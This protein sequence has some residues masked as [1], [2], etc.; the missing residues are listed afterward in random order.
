MVVSVLDLVARR[1][2]CR[3]DPSD[4]AGAVQRGER[5]VDGLQ[6]GAANARPDGL[7]ELGDAAVRVGVELAQDG[8][9]AG[10]GPWK[11]LL[12]EYPQLI[13]RPLV[14]ADDGTLSQGFSD[15]GFKKRFGVG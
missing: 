3:L 7:R 10:V 4:Q 9:P 6:R 13:K 15:N 14:I 11:L 2:A 8:D 5:V 1:L 12:R